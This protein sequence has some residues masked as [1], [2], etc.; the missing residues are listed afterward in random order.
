MITS[1]ANAKVKH[2]RRLQVEKRYRWREGQ[3]VVEGTRWLSEL[4]IPHSPA[5]FAFVTEEWLASAPNGR[6]LQQVACPYQMVHPDVMLAMSDTE[7]PPGVLAVVAMRPRP[8]PERPTCILV[9][10]AITNPGNLGTILRTAGAACVD[11]VLLG[12]GC[13]DPYNPKVVRGSMGALLRLPVHVMTSWEA[14]ATAVAGMAIWVGTVDGAARYT[15]VDWQQPSALIVGSEAHGA[16]AQALA[17]AT[18]TVNIPM[19]NALESLNAAMAAGVILFE[20][21]RQ[22]F[23]W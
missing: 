9:L 4:A 12:P 17:L 23:G 16:S 22:R 14:L 3:F 6:I 18:G 8:L 5:A 2:V 19:C 15:A 10:D 7:T 1:T 21:A 20:A 13:V 11:G